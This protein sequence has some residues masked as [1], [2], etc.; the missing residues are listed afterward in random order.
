MDLGIISVRYAKALLRFAI[1]LGESEA[2]YAETERLVRAFT[3]TPALQ[4]ALTNPVVS[5]ERKV[6]LIL[7]AA[8]ASGKGDACTRSLQRFAALVVSKGRTELM[9]YIAPSYG[10]LYRNMNHLI[11]GRL[12]VS[13]PVSDQTV[14]QLKNK[15]ESLSDS[16]IDFSIEQDPAIEGGFILEYGTYRLDASVRTQ[17][18]QLRRQ[19]A[20]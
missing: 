18:A 16:A 13:A 15:V 20:H 8:S 3:H 5:N 14:A 11:K 12:I 9:L 17:L 7:T 10:T 1:E 2:V 6:Q 4:Q 19:L